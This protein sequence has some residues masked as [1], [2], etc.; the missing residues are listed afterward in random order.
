[1]GF[2]SIVMG[3]SPNHF[4]IFYSNE[5]L[6]KVFKLRF[7]EVFDQTRPPSIKRIR[8]NYQNNELYSFSEVISVRNYN[9]NMME[10]YPFLDRSPAE[11]W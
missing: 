1:T 5:E 8:V 4:F 2:V 10:M 6:I 9:P 3:I 11:I 7:E